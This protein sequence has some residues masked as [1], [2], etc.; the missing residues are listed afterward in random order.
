MDGGVL[1]QGCHLEVGGL[2]GGLRRGGG[3]LFMGGVA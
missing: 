2:L 1:F 3:G